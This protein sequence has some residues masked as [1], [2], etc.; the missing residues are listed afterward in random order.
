MPCSEPRPEGRHEG[1]RREAQTRLQERARRRAGIPVGGIGTAAWAISRRSGASVSTACGLSID[2]VAGGGGLLTVPALCWRGLTRPG[3][4]D[5]QG[6]G[7]V[8]GRL[9]DLRR[10]ARKGLIH[11]AQ[12]W[13]IAAGG[14]L[15]AASPGR[16]ASLS[17]PRRAR[18]P[19][20]GA[21]D[22][23]RDLFRAVPQGLGRG[24]QR[25]HD[26]ADLRP[27][28]ARRDRGSTTASSGPAPAR[29]ICSP[30]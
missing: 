23:H 12:A 19:D 24:C 2:A 5:Q 11:G 22:R 9:R 3:R 6:A 29:S 8:R 4:R 21:A 15:Q 17:A 16:S 13:R 10:S 18:N 14:I 28:G 30:S 1:F 20:P 27:R 7:L 25:A 26:I